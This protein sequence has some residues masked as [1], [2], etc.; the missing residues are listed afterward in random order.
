MICRV[1]NE[2]K[3]ADQFAVDRKGYTESRCR[4]CYNALKRAKYSQNR[5][6]S[7]R[8]KVTSEM[9]PRTA[10]TVP[11]WAKDWKPPVSCK[12]CRSKIF[13]SPGTFPNC[14]MCGWEDLSMPATSSLSKAGTFLQ[15]TLKQAGFYS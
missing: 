12:R 4:P 15:S 8:R 5:E 3:A 11:E 10:R 13:F 2:D 1:C 6:N 7:D 14:V 9:R